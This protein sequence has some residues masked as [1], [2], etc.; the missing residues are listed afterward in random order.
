[1][2]KAR[3]DRRDLRSHPTALRLRCGEVIHLDKSDRAWHRE[4]NQLRLRYREVNQL[5]LR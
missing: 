3:L 5:R 1:M 4:V 2:A